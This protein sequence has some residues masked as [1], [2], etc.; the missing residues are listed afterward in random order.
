MGDVRDRLA[1]AQRMAIV[2][3]PAQTS[4]QV[5]TTLNQNHQVD[6][7]VPLLPHVQLV[8]LQV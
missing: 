1:I 2:D 7:D 5:D 3:L 4:H 8:L 6:D